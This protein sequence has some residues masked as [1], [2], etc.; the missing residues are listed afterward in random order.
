MAS[1][2]EFEAIMAENKAKLDPQLAINRVIYGSLNPQTR[3]IGTAR[4]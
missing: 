4:R 2:P 3:T 1:N